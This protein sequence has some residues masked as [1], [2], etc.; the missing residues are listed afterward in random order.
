[1]L[2]HLTMARTNFD[3]AEFP[4]FGGGC[5]FDSVAGDANGSRDLLSPTGIAQKMLTQ[6]LSGH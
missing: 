3:P 4:R 6:S 2:G 1:M 5:R